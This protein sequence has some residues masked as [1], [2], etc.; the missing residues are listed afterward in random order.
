MRRHYLVT[1]DVADDKRRTT[2]HGILR[3][4]G[5]HVQYSVFLCDLS[6]S[7][8]ASLKAKVAE[9][10]N[11]RED[12]TLLVDLGIATVP[13]DSSIDCMGKPYDPVPRVFIV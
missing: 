13:I 5:D 7:E 10:L 3:D 9:V 4:Y 8:L 12:Q 11:S 2:L 6:A 1:Y